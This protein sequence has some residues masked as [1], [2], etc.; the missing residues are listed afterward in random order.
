MDGEIVR[1]IARRIFRYLCKGINREK[2]S[3]I[4][5]K[6]DVRIDIYIDK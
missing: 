3:L 5:T 1:Q 4:D 6:I 2:G